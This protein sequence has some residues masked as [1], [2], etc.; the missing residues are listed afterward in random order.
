LSTTP[1]STPATSG[2]PNPRT[3]PRCIEEAIA[4]ELERLG[5]TA[6]EGWAWKFQR[7]AYG[8]LRDGGWETTGEAYGWFLESERVRSGAAPRGALVWYGG[9]SDGP[10]VV[11]SLG[12]GTAVGPGQDG[13]VRIV[14][15]GALPGLLGWTEALFPLAR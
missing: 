15:I 8:Y 2:P 7:L 5:S 14:S 1:S 10:S 4:W 11:C 3:P 9:S 6:W 13:A 12:D